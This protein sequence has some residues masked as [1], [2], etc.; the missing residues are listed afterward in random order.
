MRKLHV[1]ILLLLSLM[2]APAWAKYSGLSLS[3]EYPDQTVQAGRPVVVPLS[4]HNYGLAPQ[5]VALTVAE[6][7]HGWKAEFE[8]GAR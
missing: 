4:V 8:G 7:P 2:C 5:Q 3:T 1:G 6:A